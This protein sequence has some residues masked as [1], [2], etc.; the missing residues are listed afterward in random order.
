MLTAIYFAAGADEALPATFADRPLP[1]T[2]FLRN[3]RVSLEAIERHMDTIIRA[4]GDLTLNSSHP[5]GGNPMSDNRSV[6]VVDA[7]CRVHGFRN[8]FVC[9]ASVFPTSVRINP[10]LTIMA[11]ADYMW[12]RSIS[13]DGARI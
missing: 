12:R 7:G 5:Q 1:R 13:Q 2:D 3:G 10:Q 11:L 4:P 6:G 9:D 8:L